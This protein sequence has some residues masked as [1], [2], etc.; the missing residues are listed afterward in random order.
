M[1]FRGIGTEGVM[2]AHVVAAIDGQI[3]QPHGITIEVQHPR[4][5]VPPVRVAAGDLHPGVQVHDRDAM[6][7]S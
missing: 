5:A 7:S 3:D 1:H 4:S 2:A 6:A